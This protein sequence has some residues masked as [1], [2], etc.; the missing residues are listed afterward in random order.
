LV[1]I[2]AFFPLCLWKTISSIS[3][4][5]FLSEVTPTVFR[6][7]S[8]HLVVFFFSA[9][10]AL[11]GR[12]LHFGDLLP[13]CCSCTIF[14]EPGVLVSPDGPPRHPPDPAALAPAVYRRLVQLITPSTTR[15]RFFP[16]FAGTF[17]FM[18]K[19][20]SRELAELSKIFAP[21][22]PQSLGVTPII[23]GASH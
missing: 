13:I 21:E 9:S 16:L 23:S 20:L 5:R 8:P 22:F 4:G 6:Q 2:W 17:F 7:A 18:S 19:S 12:Y 1:G 15:L 3:W 10:L 14:G 11:V